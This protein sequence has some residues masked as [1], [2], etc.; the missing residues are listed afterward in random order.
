MQGLSRADNIKIG[1]L[2]CRLFIIQLAHALMEFGAPMHK[3]DEQLTAACDFLSIKAHFVLFN[4]VIILVFEDPDGASP[5]QKHFIQRPQG[6]SLK[7]LQRTHAV[8][9]AVIHD[10]ISATEGARQLKAI[11]NHQ[12]MY[13][14]YVKILFAF[15]AGFAI[16]PMG[17]SGSFVDSLVAGTSSA[18]LMIVQLLRGGDVLFTGIF[19]YAN[20]SV[21]FSVCT[22]ALTQPFP[23]TCKNCCGNIHIICC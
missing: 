16:C 8:Y 13:G 3:I 14:I 9:S 2:Q 1:G 17:F 18:F 12:E 7:R 23:R 19:E 20:Y 11:M 15:L 10:R 21:L 22:T 6:L 4:T 5:S